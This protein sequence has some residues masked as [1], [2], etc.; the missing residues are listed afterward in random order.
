MTEQEW[1]TCTSPTPML[2]FLQGKVSSRKLRLLAV[3]YCR[4]I[5]P[6][7]AHWELVDGLKQIEAVAD[8]L[9]DPTALITVAQ[10]A[11]AHLYPEMPPEQRLVCQ[12]V[13]FA[14]YFDELADDSGAFGVDDPD[15]SALPA[16]IRCSSAVSVGMVGERGHSGYIRCVFGNPFCPV[17]A[18]PAWLTSNVVALA[19]GIYTDHAF[20][21]MPIL[22]DALQD[23]GCDN[24][25]ILTHCRNEAQ[26][27]RGCW[28]VDLLLGKE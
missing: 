28:V 13:T 4:Q 22:A 2:A 10:K 17:A 24:A 19:T 16:A 7:F 3:A 18:D 5:L 11:E 6:D 23:A 26:H 20:D 12:C 15:R 1:L 9:L 25:D 14:S 21:R 27:V 8:Q